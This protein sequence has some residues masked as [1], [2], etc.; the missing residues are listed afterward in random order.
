M[1]DDEL[2]GQQFVEHGAHVS[3]LVE[4]GHDDR[5]KLADL[6]LVSAL[7]DRHVGSRRHARGRGA[8][9]QAPREA[10]YSSARKDEV[11]CAGH[12]VRRV[13]ARL[14]D[15]AQAGA[16]EH[17]AQVLG[18]EVDGLPVKEAPPV[19]PQEASRERGG[20]AVD[21]DEQRPARQARREFG[22]HVRG[23]W[24]C[25]QHV[26]ENDQLDVVADGRNDR[27]NVGLV[28][29][30][31]R[32]LPREPN[33]VDGRRRRDALLASHTTGDQHT[34][35][36]RATLG[37]IHVGRV[38]QHVLELLADV[39]AILD[40]CAA[41]RRLNV[42]VV[43]D[44]ARRRV[45]EDDVAAAALHEASAALVEE[46][47]L[48]IRAARRATDEGGVSARARDRLGGVEL[49]PATDLISGLSG[50][51][52]LRWARARPPD[53]RPVTGA[54]CGAGCQRPGKDT[55]GG[56]IIGPGGLSRG[57]PPV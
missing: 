25:L 48:G 57:S 32:L 17:A 9:A 18:V 7:E 13:H 11:E 10:G 44:L 39:L 54:R 20:V 45:D 47:P 51:M 5:Q 12:R 21:D 36:G 6:R 41:A 37:A 43:A 46:V 19:A 15:E 34:R 2:L 56:A 40:R 23:A 28:H 8:E 50:H 24:A 49:E 42:E 52:S 26:V 30:A 38:A 55:G 16:L 1:R 31:Q 29:E 27:R 14:P 3:C 53:Q 35:G 22:D 33:R 4:H